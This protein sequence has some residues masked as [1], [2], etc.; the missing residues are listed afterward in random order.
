MKK[1][2]ILSILLSLCLLI[3]LLPTVALAAD[4]TSAEAGIRI[5][6]GDAYDSNTGIFSIKVQAKLPVGT[7]ISSVGTLLSYDNTKLAVVNKNNPSKDVTSNESEKKESEAIISKT[8]I[9]TVDDDENTKEYTLQDSAMYKAGDRSG[10]YTFHYNGKPGTQKATDAQTGGNWFDVY[11]VMFRVAGKPAD[12][13]T[14]L[15]SDSLRIADVAKGDDAVMKGA[16]PANN[17]YSIY[18]TDNS[19]PARL[20]VLNRMSEC[21]ETEVT[22]EKR[23]MTAPETGTATYPGSDNTPSKPAASVATAPAAKTDLKYNGNDQALVSDGTANGGTMQYSLDNSSWSTAIPK[24]TD[25]K[26]YTV[27]YKV[28]GDSSHSDYTPASNTVTVKIDPKGISS[29]TID[30]IPNQ[31]YDGGNELKPLPVVKDGTTVLV[32]GKDYTVSYHYNTNAGSA[33]LQVNGMG[34]Y[35]GTKGATFNIDRAEQELTVP[36]DIYIAFGN[37]KDLNTVCSSNMPGAVLAFAKATTA[38]TPSGTTF[39]AATG[40]VT[41]GNNTGSFDVTVNSAGNANYKDALQKTITVYIVE[42]EAST[43]ATEPTAKTGLKYDGTEQELVTAGTANGGTVKY[44]LNGTTWTDTVPKGKNAGTYNVQY[45]IEGDATH[46]DTVPRTR[47]VEIGH[48]QVTVSGIT[49]KNKMYD[50]GISA[51][52]I[53]SGV[54]FGGIVSGD[55]LTITATGKFTDAKVGDGKTVNLTLGTLGGTSASNYKLAAAGNQTTTSANIT[56]KEVTVTGITATNRTYAKDNL[57]V[58]LTGGTLTGVISG[59]TVTVDLTNAKGTMTDANVGNGKA[60]TVTGVALGGADKGNYR[61]KAQPAGV[62][63]NITKATGGTLAAY[64]FQQKYTDLT[65]KTIT[66]DYSD[67]PAGQTWTYSTPTPTTSGT[68]AVTGTSIGADTG[69]LSY[70]LT[71]G[72]KDNTVKWTVTI[73]SH[74]YADFTKEVILTLTDKDDQTPLTLTG[75]TTV[76]YGQTLQLGTSGGTGTGAVTYAVT[77]GTGEATIDAATGKLTPVKVGTVTVTATK[78]ADANYNPVTSAPVTITITKATPTG[79]P[80]YTAITAEGKT[81]ADA[82]LT[83]G[84]ITPEGTIKWVD[85]PTTAVEANK[86]YSWVFTPNETANYET[87]TGSIQLWHKSTGGRYYYSSSNSSGTATITAVLTAKDAKSATDYTSGIYGLTFR[88]TADFSGFKGV[89][90][91]G[92]TIGKDNY[93]AESN[94]GSI[95]VYLK[96]AYLKT[97]AVGRHTLTIMATGGNASIDFTIGGV[98]TAPKTFD[99]GIAVY[100]TMAVA[101]VTGMAWMGKKR[102]D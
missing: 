7:G 66:P 74:N 29:V 35:E 19:D 14:V 90:V 52:I 38:S 16:F 73:S 44:S 33:A 82:G 25:A 21:G 6:Q 65:A 61:L 31:I 23:L 42:K 48:K 71:A 11:E 76:V 46:K 77:N 72:A 87:L 4:Q 32:K 49:A 9:Q 93:V 70:T 1:R 64:N 85:L 51:T 53:T 13:A 67:L 81:L 27:Y 99:A 86:S 12:P 10:I 39:D 102:E 95:E 37:T 100:V 3:S 17:I 56:V 88:S 98:N 36:S 2:K 75:G 20:Y 22:D 68:A 79:A 80:G 101:S 62:T 47:T 50:G 94:N 69:V 30:P 28:K 97:L 63:V 91:D 43:Y 8:L 83:V 34:N 92:K 41:A 15:N 5:V 78:A 18:L 26:T 84:T 89:K 40:T 57:K 45:K 54:T 59:D 58:A 24:G 96:A 60:V 55:K